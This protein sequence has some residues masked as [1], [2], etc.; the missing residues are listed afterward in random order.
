MLLSRR[1]FRA[2]FRH[3]FD[4]QRDVG[5]TASSPRSGPAPTAAAK[6]TC[7]P[8]SIL[9]RNMRCTCSAI[10]KAIWCGSC[11]KCR[12]AAT[13]WSGTIRPPARS[14][15][16]PPPT[17]LAA[18]GRFPR[19]V[20]TKINPTGSREA[21]TARSLVPVLIRALENGAFVMQG[22]AAEAA[23]ILGPS[24]AAA[25]PAL[26]KR[27]ELPGHEANTEVYVREYVQTQARSAIAAI[28]RGM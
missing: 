5:P 27:L 16:L 14:T 26:R 15:H 12:Q 17:I 22:R 20:F 24:A 25:L 21:E 1:R 3:A 6:A 28:E 7:T 11:S 8:W 10:P 9:A 19:H 18:A 13:N 23:G 4:L 2:S